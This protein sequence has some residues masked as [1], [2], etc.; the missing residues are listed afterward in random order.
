MILLLLCLHILPEREFFI[1][2][3]NDKGKIGKIE[4][5]SQKDS[6]G[7][8]IVYISDRKIEI[9]LDSL[10][11]GTL[12]I[13]KTINDRQILKIVREKKFNVYF[14]GHK[15]TYHEDGPVY[16]RHTLDFALRGFDYNIEYENTIRLHIPEFMIINAELKV[17]GEEIISGPVGEILCWKVRV[18][19]RIFFIRM[20]FYIWIEKDS[21]HR[22]IKY[23][24]SSG[25]NYIQ[26]INS[27]KYNPQS[28]N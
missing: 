14:K 15:M 2:E 27:R 18:I 20:K 4:V 11:L 6:L 9:V 22:F 25:K 12:Y 28:N 1:Y 19:P 7:Y 13:S 5:T 26:L 21:P 8:H 10:T 24:D 23:A 3:T 16:D 17:V